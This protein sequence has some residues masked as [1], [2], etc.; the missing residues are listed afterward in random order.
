MAELT[1]ELTFPLK[2][3]PCATQAVGR[4]Q[5]AFIKYI[6]GRHNHSRSTGAL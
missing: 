3:F 2:D 6:C 4:N 5:E 1:C